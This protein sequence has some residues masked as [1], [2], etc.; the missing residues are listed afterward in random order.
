MGIEVRGV[1]AGSAAGRIA[2]GDGPTLM[3]SSI[4]SMSECADEGWSGM[5]SPRP[6][7]WGCDMAVRQ[8]DRSI[9][10]LGVSASTG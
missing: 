5:V 3:R 6:L 7:G 8:R 9:M 1:E 2:A 10:R 4:S